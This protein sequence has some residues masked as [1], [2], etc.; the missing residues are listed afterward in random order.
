MPFLHVNDALSLLPTLNLLPA[1]YLCSTPFAKLSCHNYNYGMA[2]FSTGSSDKAHA[3]WKYIGHVQVLSH[4]E[5]A[6]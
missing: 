4:V 5:A 2:F 6:K 1:H 3:F